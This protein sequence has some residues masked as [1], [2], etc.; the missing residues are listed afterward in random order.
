L[1]GR[2]ALHLSSF[3]QSMTSL[4][5]CMFALEGFFIMTKRSVGFGDKWVCAGKQAL[6]CMH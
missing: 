2:H 1:S 5:P 6:H 3:P 4:D